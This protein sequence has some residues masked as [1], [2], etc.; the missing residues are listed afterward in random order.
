[1]VRHSLISPRDDACSAQGYNGTVL[2]YGQ[3]GSGKTHTMSGGVGIHGKME[4]GEGIQGR[5][6]YWLHVSQVTAPCEQSADS[7]CC[8]GVVCCRRDATRDPPR[9]CH[10]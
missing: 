10:G 2:A 1:M 8:G 4:E 7:C 6:S 5:R 9:V 3:T